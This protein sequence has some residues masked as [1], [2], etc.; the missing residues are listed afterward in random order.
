MEYRKFGQ[1]W[2]LRLD[3]GEEV[4]ASLTAFCR[5]ENVRLGS[6]EG[7]GASDHTVIGVYLKSSSVRNASLLS[8]MLSFAFSLW[9]ARNTSTPFPC[10]RKE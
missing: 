7:L 2:V 9:S 6:V 8:M 1:T 5:E 4:I 3:R 10:Q